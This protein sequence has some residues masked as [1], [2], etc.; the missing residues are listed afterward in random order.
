MKF[1]K[2]LCPIDFSPP[3]MHALHMAISL[4]KASS[5]ELV[6]VHSWHLPALYYSE[7]AF[8][9]NVVDAMEEG[10]AAELAKAMRE[11]TDS[12]VNRVST[13]LLEGI[14]AD[15]IVDAVEA[16][17]TVDLVVL[18]A[19]GRSGFGR[20]LMGSV[21]EK[22]VRH[23]PCSVLAIHPTHAIRS[24]RS[25]LCPVDFSESSLDAVELA[26]RLLDPG[27]DGLTLLHVLDLPASYSGHP[28]AAAFVSALDVKS[29]AQ[30]DSI[31]TSP[32]TTAAAAKATIKRSTRVGNPGRQILAML[33]SEPRY[34]LVV[35]GTHGR[36]GLRR[37]VL[38]SIAEKIVRNAPCPVIVARKR[39]PSPHVR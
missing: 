26:L 2:I 29:T 28:E 10:A 8:P 39:L 17:P 7:L 22:I 34:D 16:D 35:V 12:G 21:A 6:I 24:F 15:V 38:G 36:T 3:S 31:L 18:G 14:P 32:A 1:T 25:I 37:V 19:N 4:A 13:H 30:L 5:C 27:G 9:S 33:E 11:A 20:V 23:A